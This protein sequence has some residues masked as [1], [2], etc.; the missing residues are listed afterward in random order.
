MPDIEDDSVTLGNGPLVKR[1]GSDHSEQVVGSLAG[2][3]ELLN[4]I[5]A[6]NS[7]AL[8]SQHADL[9]LGTG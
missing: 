6:D 1:I 9:L 8:R 4:E 2:V 7:V 3:R 5:V